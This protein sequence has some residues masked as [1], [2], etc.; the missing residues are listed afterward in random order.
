[1]KTVKC[2]TYNSNS[3]TYNSIYCFQLLLFSSS[4]LS[5]RE[6]LTAFLNKG[7]KKA[8]F[9]WCQFPCYLVIGGQYLTEYTNDQELYVLKDNT[10]VFKKHDTSIMLFQGV[11]SEWRKLLTTENNFQ[12]MLQAIM[13]K[14]EGKEHMVIFK[15]WSLNLNLGLHQNK[16]TGRSCL[17][18]DKLLLFY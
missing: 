12:A 17:L 9:L 8:T 6:Y 13:S 7:Q 2:T 4:F 11:I 5:I 10:N 14:A 16:H 1:M 15:F 18:R 3:H